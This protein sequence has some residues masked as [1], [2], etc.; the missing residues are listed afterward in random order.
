MNTISLGV[1]LLSGHVLHTACFGILK[2]LAHF[3]FVETGLQPSFGI[4][5]I[6]CELSVGVRKSE[7]VALRHRVMPV[8]NGFG[9]RVVGINNR[10]L[11]KGDGHGPALPADQHEHIGG[12]GI[13]RC[14]TLDFDGLA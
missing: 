1:A 5:G 4:G 9:G 3:R 6:L 10:Q 13:F 2:G 14:H 12:T 8:G 7:T 11:G